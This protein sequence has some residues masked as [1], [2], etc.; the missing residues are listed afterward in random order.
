MCR[1]N[2]APEPAGTGG[3]AGTDAAFTAL[4]EDSAEDLYESAPCGYLSTMM[5][6]TIAKINTTLLDWL[7]LEREAVVGR[8]RFTDLLTVGGKLYHET[9]F[10]PLL[11]M[12]GELRGIA[13]DLK[14][15]GGGRLPV[16][17]SAVVKYGAQ[18]EPLL[19]R[20]TAFDASDRRS[21]ETELLHRRKEA[22]RARAEADEARRQAEADRARLADALA[23]LQRSLVPDSLPA[24][25]GLET[26]VHYHTAAPEQLGGDFYDLFPVAG[27]RWAFFL[28]DVC[29]K[30]PEAASLTS[31][32]RYTLRAAAHH[33]PEPAAALATLNAVLH[34]RY[35]AGGDPRYC[36]CVFGIIE[37]GGE[38]GPTIV[39]LASGGHPPALVLRSG[40]RAE[41]LP[42]PGGLL[43][44]VLPDAPI[45]TVETVLAAGD[46][47]VLYT[48]GLTEARTGPGRDDLYGEDA[49]R[50]FGTDLAPA[51]PGEVI[52]ALTGLLDSFGDG[53][54]D[55]TALLALGVPAD[56][57]LIRPATSLPS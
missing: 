16:L 10:A 53:L 7:G 42:T 32:T 34:E 45:S 4:L 54:N 8:K 52:T 44:G 18:G 47:I 35:T 22:E 17:A 37:P 50:V 48:D 40:G 31:L 6:G 3:A 30:G 29:G 13:L 12:Q 57:S 36:T 21:Y 23:V 24:V 20:V 14:R 51:A 56:S 5:D 39:R 26:A 38:H 1:A 55:D 28:G 27:D 9:H 46:T 43:V 41:F 2:G 15:Q 19:I 25:P 11:R 33:D 49:L